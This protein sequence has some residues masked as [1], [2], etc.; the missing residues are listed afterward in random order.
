MKREK[1][2][3]QQYA[4]MVFSRICSSRFHNSN[5]YVNEVFSK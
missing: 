3:M 1:T 5:S 2:F 4:A